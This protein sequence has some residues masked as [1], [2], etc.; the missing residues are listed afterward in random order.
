MTEDP[1]DRVAQEC[2]ERVMAAAV[3]VRA[4][5]REDT[6]WRCRTCGGQR[7]MGGPPWYRPDIREAAG[8]EN[9]PTF[10]LAIG[11]LLRTKELEEDPADFSLRPGP[12][13]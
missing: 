13:F 8:I 6:R 11:H 2:F 12:N 5:L 10:S 4:A 9:G 1:T 3:A 7:V